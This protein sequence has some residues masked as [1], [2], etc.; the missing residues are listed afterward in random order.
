RTSHNYIDYCCHGAI[1]IVRRRTIS[2]QF[3]T[4]WSH[5]APRHLYVCQESIVSVRAKKYTV[6]S[7]DYQ[8]ICRGR[9]GV[10]AVII[11]WSRSKNS[12][13]SEVKFTK[14][15]V[16]AA[17]R[18]WCTC[19]RDSECCA[20]SLDCI[21]FDIIHKKGIVEGIGFNVQKLQITVAD[22]GGR[23]TIAVLG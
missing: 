16:R 8:R 3:Y 6:E 17:R 4:V 9:S 7:V 18:A 13:T 22:A 12:E 20:P 15:M 10:K 23:A 11:L 19:Q 21:S 2:R 14:K 5:I 1:I